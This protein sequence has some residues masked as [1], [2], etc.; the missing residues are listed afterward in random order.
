LVANPGFR[1]TTYVPAGAIPPESKP[2]AAALAGQK[3][4]FAGRIQITVIEEGQAVWLAFINRELD[5]L[6]RIPADFIDQ[7]LADGKLRPELA[8]KGMR[9]EALLRPNTR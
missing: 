1:D 6:E 8:A 9:H 5:L 3:L 4:P 2:I 7:A